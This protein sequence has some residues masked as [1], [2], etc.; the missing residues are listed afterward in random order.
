[1][2]EDIRGYD[3]PDR[4]SLFR[5]RIARS[6]ASERFTATARDDAETARHYLRI[7]SLSQARTNIGTPLDKTG[8][9]DLE[10]GD[11]EFGLT[12]G[13]TTH[14]IRVSVERDGHGADTNHDLLQ[15][16]SRQINAAD[17][18]LSAYVDVILQ[19]DENGFAVEKSVMVIQ[20]ASTGSEA[21]FSLEDAN[22]DLVA[23]IGLNRLASPGA[24][25][26]AQYDHQDY[27]S[28]TNLLELQDDGL[29]V[30]MYQPTGSTETIQVEKGLEALLNQTG[31][32]LNT[33]ND[34]L[35]F[36]I[37]NR[38]FLKTATLTD[39]YNQ[40]DRHWRD[41]RDIGFAH[42]GF[43][44]LDLTAVFEQTLVGRPEQAREALLDEGGF[45]TDVGH[46]INAQL[47]RNP[48]NLVRSSRS[49]SSGSEG[50][51]GIERELESGL[52]LSTVV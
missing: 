28:Q 14:D 18:R 49:P 51:F 52:F 39:I 13:D 1:M 33:Y 46:L 4:G 6:S 40:L 11:Y 24:A 20:A 15:K 35:E 31:D 16:I 17:D 41:L 23:R 48:A 43:G 8:E 9:T 3:I 32:L 27:E 30:N 44:R 36:T 47:Y 21:S 5:S 45:F 37:K 19:P 26:D 50:R 42:T 10:D 2:S 38:D 12:V 25:A 22:G 34:Y 7:D 29:V